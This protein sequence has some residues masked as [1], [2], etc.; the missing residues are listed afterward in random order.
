MDDDTKRDVRAIRRTLEVAAVM[1]GV[2]VVL[3]IA[4]LWLR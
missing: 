2:L 4:A 3:A 1:L